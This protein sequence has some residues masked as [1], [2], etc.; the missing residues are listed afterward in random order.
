LNTD[1]DQQRGPAGDYGGA[2]QRYHDVLEVDP[3]NEEAKRGLSEAEKGSRLAALTPEQLQAHIA[4]E[5]GDPSAGGGSTTPL[6]DVLG[7]FLSQRRDPP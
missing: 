4:A 2:Q 1:I 6:A 3:D 7:N 5:M